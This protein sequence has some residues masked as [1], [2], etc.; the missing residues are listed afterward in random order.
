[1]ARAYGLGGGSS[2]TRSVSLDRPGS[3]VRI[4][5]SWDLPASGSE[6][7]DD[8]DIHFL[9]A[10]TVSLG[11]QGT[12]TV[13]P[14]GIPAAEASG[15]NGIGSRGGILRWDQPAAVVL[16]DEWLLDDPLLAS[17]WGTKLTRLRFRMPAQQRAAGSFTLT[18]EATP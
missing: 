5:D 8:V 12:A 17:V 18:M 7:T 16:V 4:E 11:P 14:L 10:G 9:L 15:A 1:L 3:R 2:W 6:G 13:L